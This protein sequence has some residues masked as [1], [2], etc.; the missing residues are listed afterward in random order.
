MGGFSKAVLASLL[1]YKINISP[2]EPDIPIFFFNLNS[3]RKVNRVYGQVWKAL[4]DQLRRRPD[5]ICRK[6]LTEADFN[7]THQNYATPQVFALYSQNDILLRDYYYYDTQLDYFTKW[8]I[9]RLYK[10]EKRCRF[11]QTG[12]IS[13]SARFYYPMPKGH[14]GNQ[15]ISNA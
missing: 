8:M 4:G 11:H 3:D 13:F 15:K 12:R 10:K 2:L 14:K 6:P 5:G 1:R 7:E 9:K